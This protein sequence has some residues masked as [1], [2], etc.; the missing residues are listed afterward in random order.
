MSCGDMKDQ[1]CG[2]GSGGC[3]CGDTNQSSG[4][5]SGGCGCGGQEKM[6]DPH[7]M[8]E[9]FVA[10]AE[11]A[12]MKALKHK[13]MDHYTKKY[14]KEMDKTAEM[15]CEAAGMKWMDMSEFEKKKPEMLKEFMKHMEEKKKMKK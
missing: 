3:G 5:G 6:M 11:T 2:C 7:Q 1:A 10:L 9:M 14:G 15:F 13:M 4:C 12:W 8:F